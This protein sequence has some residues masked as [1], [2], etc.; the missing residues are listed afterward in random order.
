MC[1]RIPV[2]FNKKRGPIPPEAVYIGRP[3]KWGNPFEIGKDGTRE[4]V[5]RLYREWL[6]SQ[7]TL[8]AAVKRELKGKDLVCWC[9]PEACHGE[10]LMEVANDL[11]VYRPGPE[12]LPGQL[13]LF[14]DMEAFRPRSNVLPGQTALF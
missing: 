11:E 5:I 2:L 8:V 14:D 6:Y 9:S 3:S 7:P 10:V 13:G 12:V 4:E 1:V